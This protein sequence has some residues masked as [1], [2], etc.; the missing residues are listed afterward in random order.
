M[1]R[2]VAPTYG[3]PREII[4]LGDRAE[5]GYT[6]SRVPRQ[7]GIRMFATMPPFSH[8][9]KYKKNQIFKAIQSAGLNPND[10]KFEDKD[11]AVRLKHNPLRQTFRKLRFQMIANI[12]SGTIGPSQALIW[13]VTRFTSTAISAPV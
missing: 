11:A 6:R 5:N 2:I 12:N 9:A 1:A 3:A 10:F 8:L 7:N 13:S 4:R